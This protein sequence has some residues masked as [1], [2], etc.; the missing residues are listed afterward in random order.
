MR[1][2]RTRKRSTRRK[3]E[4]EEE[5]AEEEE[6]AHAEHAEDE[7][8]GGHGHEG[9]EEGHGDE[10]GHGEEASGPV[11]G[12][13]EMDLGQ[14]TLTSFQPASGTTLLVDFH[15][16]VIVRAESAGKFK[17]LYERNQHRIRDQVIVTV[18]SAEMEDL[19]DPGLGL[20]KRRILEK[21][22]S[23]LGKRLAQEVIFSDFTFVEQ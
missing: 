20:I 7:G 18:R 3:P 15:L 11:T 21:V 12:E 9:E 16:Y 6:E 10:E 23:G 4:A 13:R 22:N 14:F 2:P 5:H 17:A 19:T 1:P 8:H